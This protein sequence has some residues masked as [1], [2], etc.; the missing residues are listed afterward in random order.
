MAET[1]H[2]PGLEQ[3]HFSSMMSLLEFCFHCRHRPKLTSSVMSDVKPIIYIFYM[4]TSFNPNR[5]TLCCWFVRTVARGLQFNGN[6]DGTQSVI[7]GGVTV[8]GRRSGFKG[9]THFTA[10]SLASFQMTIAP[11]PHS[12]ARKASSHSLQQLIL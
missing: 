4:F 10:T 7:F 9:C 2:C 6:L 11:L 5:L 12:L 1:F 8:V 3:G